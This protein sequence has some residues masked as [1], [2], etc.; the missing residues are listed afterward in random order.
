MT[1]KEKKNAHTSQTRTRAHITN[2]HT[3]STQQQVTKLYSH[4]N[5]TASV[6]VPLRFS[7]KKSP[8]SFATCVVHQQIANKRALPK[9]K[10]HFSRYASQIKRK[11]YSSVSTVTRKTQDAE[12]HT[13]LLLLSI[14]KRTIFRVFVTHCRRTTRLAKARIRTTARIN[15]NVRA[16]DLFVRQFRWKNKRGSGHQ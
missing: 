2:A 12:T 3:S 13:R 6:F 9:R 7:V 15:G 4:A 5:L 14:P 10:E 16:V 1:K 8:V 11:S